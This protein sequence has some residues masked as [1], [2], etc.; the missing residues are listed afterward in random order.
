[1]PNSSQNKSLNHNR[2]S[3]PLDASFTITASPV[4]KRRKRRIDNEFVDLFMHSLTGSGKSVPGR[5]SK[6][7]R[8][9]ARDIDELMSSALKSDPMLFEAFIKN[10]QKI[11]K[12]ILGL[13]YSGFVKFLSS[14][15]PLDTIR[16][17]E[18]VLDNSEIESVK[19]NFK[20]RP[21]QKNTKSTRRVREHKLK[22][23]KKGGV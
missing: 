19:F 7:H 18:A 5:V 9:T 15:Q 8:Q 2:R 14:V 20:A 6:E 17:R 23:I 11:M 12:K 22:P 21:L 3:K 1:M 10:P 4:G 16:I 13:E